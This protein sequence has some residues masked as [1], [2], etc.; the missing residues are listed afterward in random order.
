M[1]IDAKKLI[2]C[3]VIVIATMII[4]SYLTSA[5]VSTWYKNLEFPPLTPPNYIFPIAW[6][7]IYFTMI[8]AFYHSLTSKPEYEKE[9][10][11]LLINQLFLQILWCFCFFY[12]GYIGL[13]FLVI[14]ALDVVIINT[15]IFFYK[16]TKIS[17][18]LLLPYLGWVIFASYLNA[19]FAVLNG[20]I[21]NLSAL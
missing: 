10:K 2:Y 1:K 3:T 16:N 4:S 7:I 19:A 6:N 17:F 14:L 9:I 8:V 15:I 11:T 21:V 5:G 18:Y 20:Y 13:A 12:V